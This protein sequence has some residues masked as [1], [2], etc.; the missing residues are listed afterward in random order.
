VPT[1]GA[2]PDVRSL[3]AT[4]V[5]DDD[6]AAGGYV[7]DLFPT[8]LD[9]DGNGCDARD[10]VLAA[11]SSTPVVRSGCGVSSGR[12]I[13]LYDGVTTTDPSTLDIDHVVP[14]EEAWVSGASRWDARRRAA[15]ANDATDAGQLLA[16]SAS[17]N[18]S[19]GDRDPARWRPPDEATWCFYAQDWVIIKARWHL[20]IDT[21]E[22]D[23]LGQMLDRC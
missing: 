9:L 17:S 20:T 10:D 21:A 22:R 12:W 19:K 15:Y 3:L 16:V 13:S 5:I 18:R 11:S 23:A 4:L 8:W 7:R 1:T 6:P 14:L 2:R